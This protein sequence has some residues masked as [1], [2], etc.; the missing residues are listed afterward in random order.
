M[1]SW[2]QHLTRRPT[3]AIG[4]IF[5]IWFRQH[6]VQIYHILQVYSLSAIIMDCT[7]TF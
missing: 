2:V 4:L 5:I 3:E 1:K 6:Y 7:R